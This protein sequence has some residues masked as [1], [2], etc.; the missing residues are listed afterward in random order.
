MLGVLLTNYINIFTPED[1]KVVKV[2]CRNKSYLI[3]I[4]IY[5]L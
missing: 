2:I 5:L 4:L 1:I 3:Y